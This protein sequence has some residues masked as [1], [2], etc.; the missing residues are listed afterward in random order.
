MGTQASK[1]ERAHSGRKASRKPSRSQRDP[2]S[3]L[4]FVIIHWKS[5]P[6][7]KLLSKQKLENL[8]T[9]IW[10]ANTT[11]ARPELRW[12]K[13]GSFNED[14]LKHLRRH[15]MEEKPR[16]LEYLAAFETVK[17]LL[18][19]SKGAPSYQL[20]ILN[21]GRQPMPP[22][23]G[24]FAD[25]TVEQA[26]VPFY[27]GEPTPPIP[28][29]SSDSDEETGDGGARGRKFHSGPDAPKG[30]TD[31]AHP[32]RRGTRMVYTHQPFYTADL[33]T[34][35]NQMPSLRDDPD[36]C[37]RQISAIFSTHNP[38]WPDVHVL[39][40]ALFNE[41][42][43]ADILTKAGEA[44][45]SPD[46]QRGRPAAL[47]ALSAQCL[48]IE[49]TWDYNTTNGIWCLN[50]FKRAILDGVKAAGQRTVNWTKVQT[51]L[52]GPNE[53]PSDYYTRL[54]SAI[55]TWGGIDPENP[56]HEVIVKGFF[57]DQASPDIRKA[58]NL[59]IGYD[60]KS[61]SEILSI[62]KSVYNSRDERKRKE[63][64]PE[65]EHILALSMEPNSSR[66][67]SF[68]RGRGGRGGGPPAPHRPWGPNTG[69]CY[70]CQEEGHIKRFCP[71]LNTTTYG[72]QALSPDDPICTIEIDGHPYRCLLD[73]GATYSTLTSSHLEPGSETKKVMGLDGIPR[74]CPLSQP[75]KVTLGPLLAEHTF[76]LT[77]SPVNLLGR[78]LLCKLNATIKCS[79]DG[80]YLY[81]PEDS[82]PAFQG[83]VLEE[84]LDRQFPE[85]PPE[86]ENEL[87][88]SLWGTESA[89]VGLLLSATPVRITYRT[90]RPFPCTK[91][92]PL[93]KEAIDGLTPMIEDFLSKGILVPCA[94]PCNTPVLPIKKPS[95]E[96]APVRY[97]FVQDLRLVNQFVIPRHPV[98]GNPNSLLNAIPA[99][100]TWYS[101]AD[102]CSA[103][104]SIPLDPASQFLFAFTWGP[105]QLT[106]TRLPQGYVESPAIF[107]AI[108]HQD[109][110]DVC[111]PANSALLLYVD[112]ILLCSTSEEACKLDT[113]YL[114]SELARKGHKVSPKKLQ[115]CKQEVKYLGHILGVG[116]CRAWIAGYSE[117]TKPLTAMTRQDHPDTLV[118]EEEAYKSFERLKRELRSAPALGLPDYRTPFNLFIH[119]QMG[120][121]SGVLTQ[122]F[123][124]Q[125]RPVAYYSLQ[126]DNTAKGAVSCLRAIAAAAILLEKAQETVLGHEITIHVPHSVSTL[127]TLR[128]CHHF[129]NSRL[130]R[131]E[132]L[133]LT[134]SNVTIKRVNS[135]NPATLL[136][137]PDDGTPHHD[138]ATIV[139][140]AEKP[141]ED[142]DHLP[143]ENPDLILYTD[144]SSK[145][146]E[147]ERKTGYAVVSDFEVL[148]S[149]PINPQYSAQA[150]ELI[151]LIRACELGEGKR[152]TIYTDSKYCFGLVHTT[153]QI[154]LQRGFLTAA[155]SQI[156][157]A[158][159]VERLLTAIHLPSAIAVVHC[160][161]HTKGRDPVSK[162]NRRADKAAQI[163]ALR[164]PNNESEFQ[165]L[166]LPTDI[167]ATQIYDSA[168]EE[169]KSK[170]E[171]VGAT[172]QN[173]IWTLPD[174]R[175]VLP[176][177]WV[178][179]LVRILHQQTHWGK[180]RLIDHVT[181][182]WYAPGI[183]TAATAASKNCI[184]CHHFNPKREPKRKP[185]GA[186]PWA[187]VPFESLQLDFIDLPQCQG[188]KH[189]LIIIDQFSS[190]VEGFPCRKA[191]ASVVARAL[192]QDIIPRYGIPRRL[193][194]DR[195]T[196]F[197]AEVVQLVAKALQIKWDLH[198]PYHPQSSGQVE[199]MN[200]EIKMQLGK[201][202]R[203][204][205]LKWV[206]ALPL[207]LHN[208]RSAPTGPLKLSPFE[209][210]FGRPPPVYN[211]LFPLSE[212]D[213]GEAELTNY[214]I[215]LQT[216]LLRLHQYAAIEG[217]NLPIDVHAHSFHPGDWILVKV[218]Q[219]APLQPAWEGP[220]QVLLTSPTA[221]KVGEK[222]AWLHHTRCKTSPPPQET[223]ENPEED[224]AYETPPHSP[225][226]YID[227]DEEQTGPD[228]GQ[229]RAQQTGPDRGQVRAQ[230][231]GP[232]QSQVPTQHARPDV[233]APNWTSE[234]V[235]D[236][237]AIKLRLKCL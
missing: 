55:K 115:Y 190:W 63:A 62:A 230:Q 70:Y 44:I 204:S 203:L 129:S 219:K 93:P 225:A 112:D 106:W 74:T 68:N 18:Q 237:N 109:L 107:S 216:Q 25:D 206:N 34:W 73:T 60:G 218:Y 156:S 198:T 56:Q 6:G 125:E 83:M 69:G 151:A 108:L 173:G 149:N 61:V 2:D 195:G 52:Q 166:Q 197:T 236:S 100:T 5:I 95:T 116:F 35:S 221:V 234:I 134:P 38:T 176:R 77:S 15:L 167:D 97:R 26:L 169:E 75:A 40:N 28:S 127:L 119:E 33:V 161:A 144:G 232:D 157:H 10:P 24:H 199:R 42:E 210:L 224:Y 211:T 76:L 4:E 98:V 214:I 179:K 130:N 49:P 145:V 87:P 8:C 50:L 36:K 104:F 171:S 30:P 186:R 181:R 187:F 37:H 72:V 229:D 71:Y 138:C 153:G 16:Q 175:T 120:V 122:P 231:T 137:L 21:P 213:V 226:T 111:L 91:Q 172:E 47:A 17:G 222:N 140:Q 182:S 84:K 131:Y 66:G 12:P 110:Q 102:L 193:D 160:K 178:P 132:A 78:D 67:R 43:K 31:S 20:P 196:H 192:L 189:A 9:E 7:H 23:E 147:G 201:L 194:S 164:P 45:E 54:V 94:S 159:L 118:W 123:R 215:Q 233:T 124:D 143:L 27:Y 207:V 184:T 32:T 57:K 200:Q 51:V 64:K 212:L 22:Y 113:K 158:A 86:L 117:I 103:F 174:G 114:L 188:F 29:D 205:G 202:C 139:R 14:R 19:V 180:W 136:P 155:G 223:L 209:L 80:I 227:D 163:A 121:A 79:E 170:W 105:S 82:V 185:P 191:T 183:A 3:P 13:G 39:L 135:L 41:A 228:R 141:R 58:L 235:P 89:S 208:I 85:L 146:I 168:P 11:S 81:M 133:L 46:Y 142:L 96:G 65:T 177:A 220:Y 126:L 148:E 101:A 154:W 162:G 48:R 128:G 152:T 90:D 59:Q 150:A 99:G 165:A 1:H 88:P 53:H 217:Q 92:Y